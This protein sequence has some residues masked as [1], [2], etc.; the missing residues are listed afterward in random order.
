[1]PRRQFFRKLA[2]CEQSLM[3][4]VMI[5]Q[6]LFLACMLCDCSL[7]VSLEKILQRKWR[8][9]MKPGLCLTT[10]L[11]GTSYLLYRLLVQNLNITLL[12]KCALTSWLLC[13]MSQNHTTCFW[14]QWFI[15]HQSAAN[16]PPSEGALRSANDLQKPHLLIIWSSES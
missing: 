14:P 5:C 9:E 4:F 11:L 15:L 7:A 3:H 12:W 6:S 8:Q 10:R 13:E 2:K 16:A 1:M